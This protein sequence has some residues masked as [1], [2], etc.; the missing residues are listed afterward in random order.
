[1]GAERVDG[2]LTVGI[3]ADS[4]QLDEILALQDE[5]VAISRSQMEVVVASRRRGEVIALQT[6]LVAMPK[7]QAGD[8]TRAEDE[9]LFEISS[10]CTGKVLED[11]LEENASRCGMKCGL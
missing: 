2:L 4:C 9:A 6:G 7:A 1:M 10:A 11:A 5:Q 3:D 8:G